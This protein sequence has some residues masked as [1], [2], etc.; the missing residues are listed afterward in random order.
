MITS[1]NDLLRN[2]KEKPKKTIAVAMADE[3]DVLAAVANAN[4]EGIA[5]AVLVGNRERIFECGERAEIDITNFDIIDVETEQEAVVRS[6]QLVREHLADVLMKGTCGTA[7]LLRGVLDREHGVRS[8]NFLSHVAVF[9]A[10]GYHKLLL[11]SDGGMNIAPDVEVKVAIIENALVVAR[12]LEIERPKVALLAAVEKVNYKAMPCTVDAAVIA[13][14]AERGQIQD[15]I[16]DGPLAFDN[17]VSQHSCDVKGINSPVSGDADILIVPNIEAGNICY[18][19]LAC[20][21]KG[22]V[23][24]L[25]MGARVPIV[26]TSR[27]DSE[28]AK[29]YSIALGMITGGRSI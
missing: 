29:F 16:I 21:G 26:L 4:R 1:F 8:G 12:R 11:M 9:E 27:S 14:M 13:K 18:K 17:A 19:T 10:P 2:V 3:E 22:K 20:L 7:T 28:E 25:I 23:A 5:D 6:I 24:G 15:A